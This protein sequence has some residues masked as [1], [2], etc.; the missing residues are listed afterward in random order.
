MDATAQQLTGGWHIATR[1]PARARHHRT[2]QQKKSLVLHGLDWK[3]VQ[4]AYS[5]GSSVF[6]GLG[7]TGAFAPRSADGPKSVAPLPHGFSTLHPAF[8]ED[9]AS[10]VEGRF[11][12]KG[13]AS[14]AD[15]DSGLTEM[16]AAKPA[17]RRD[18]T[19]RRPR[20]DRPVFTVGMRKPDAMA[21][22]ATRR[23]RV[24]NR[25]REA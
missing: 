25:M 19:S 16:A 18:P 4:G 10:M 2:N 12:Q 13:I 17:A 6:L 1:A 8:T 23:R 14:A 11:P 21:R 7:G 15:A 20:V 22:A 3:H 5:F 9:G 24:R